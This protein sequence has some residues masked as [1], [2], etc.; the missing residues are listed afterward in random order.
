M[1]RT[2]N[3]PGRSFEAQGDLGPREMVAPP[4]G[5][6]QDPAYGATRIHLP[7]PAGGRTCPAR[8]DLA[9][10]PRTVTAR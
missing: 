10:P 6:A 9:S 7:S 2:V 4:L 1:T 3:L 5:E 8:Q